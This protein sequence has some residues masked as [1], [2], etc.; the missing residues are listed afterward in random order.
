MTPLDTAAVVA[1]AH[2]LDHEHAR[3]LSSEVMSALHQSGV[4]RGW[5]AAEY[6]GAALGV[7]DVL[8][9]IATLSRADGATGWCVMIANTTALTSHHL[10]ADW[11]AKIYADPSAC[12][13]GFAQPVAR[14]RVVPGGLEV[15]GRWSWGSGTDHCTWVGGGA[16]VVD[17]DG[18]RSAA[19]DGA[20]APFVFFEPAQ[21]ELHDDWHVSGLKGTASG[22]YSV[23]AAF[24]PDGRWADFMNGMPA[25]DTPLARF[26][27]LGALAAGVAAVIVGLAERAI[28]ELVDLAD[29]RPAGSSR[30]LA[31]RAPVQASL[32]SARIAVDQ[33]R[34]HLTHSC[35]EVWAV[36]EQGVTTDAAR[37][38]LRL[39][40]TGAAQRALA[41]VD[42]CYHAAG[43]A[44]IHDSN[45]LQ[46]VF[47]DA[48]VAISH[49]M[50]AER[51]LE[52]TGRFLFGLPTSTAQL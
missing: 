6:G 46:R 50:V 43:G 35:D 1:N 18:Q 45:P 14:A 28:D 51:T 23:A 25:I 27:P 42:L 49:G 36:A 24:V 8:D 13:G 39:A 22:D 15:T 10:P 12:T 40:A 19:P 4:L 47:R 17:E 3:R 20:V 30:T 37:V 26:P 41:A 16:L 48:H 52:P 2:A 44:A 21:V 5:I 34:V 33:A 11:A 7:S 38:Q 9:Q 32:A 31:E 29:R